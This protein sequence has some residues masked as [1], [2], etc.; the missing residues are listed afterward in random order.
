MSALV[1][2]TVRAAQGR[3]WAESKT[4]SPLTVREPA[5]YREKPCTRV[6]AGAESR[7]IS[8]SS[9]REDTRLNTG[10]KTPLRK[11]STGMGLGS[12]G[13]LPGGGKS[14]K[15]CSDL[16]VLLRGPVTHSS[17]DIPGDRDACPW[18]SQGQQVFSSHSPPLGSPD[19]SLLGT[20]PDHC[21]PRTTASAVLSPDLHPSCP[22]S[23]S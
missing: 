22:Q 5:T 6:A 10:W 15:R 18:A 14:G 13:M 16:L 9:E 12:L 11:R 19:T 17:R 23:R 7:N 8:A 21:G 3:C 20:T 1:G 2:P 4:Q